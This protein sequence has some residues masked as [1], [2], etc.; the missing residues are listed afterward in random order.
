MIQKTKNN[1]LALLVVLLVVANASTLFF[2][3]LHRPQSHP[4]SKTPAKFLISELKLD[5]AQQVKLEILRKEHKDSS[6]ALR[7]ELKEA[8]EAFFGLLKNSNITD[9][10]KLSAADA[11]SNI[12]KKL[13]LVT[14][15]HFKKVREICNSGQQQAFDKIIGEVTMMLS[16]PRNP[17]MEG[18]R[19]PPPPP[20]EK[21]GKN[22]MPP[23]QQEEPLQS[24][25]PQATSKGER[26]TRVNEIMTEE[27]HPTSTQ[28]LVIESA[29]GN[30]FQEMDKLLPQDERPQGPTDPA[31]R[32]AMDKIARE[33]DE[34]IRKT[35]SEKQYEKYVEAEMKMRPPKPEDRN[36]QNDM[37]NPNNR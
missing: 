11:V 31:A 17:R 18:N 27:L 9:S 6:E 20:D 35:L 4:T 21:E 14:F 37:P 3:W 15:N 26:M 32:A 22:T 8:K 25:T 2:F 36:P 33:R 30:F 16:A 12:T 7:A 5:S 34:K 19:P 1:I 24:P 13:D 10:A 28:M 23:P 29:F